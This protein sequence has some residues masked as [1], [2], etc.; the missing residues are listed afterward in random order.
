LFSTTICNN[1]NGREKEKEEKKKMK[2]ENMGGG[3]GDKSMELHDTIVMSS[4]FF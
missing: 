2:N 4:K 3:N 1:I